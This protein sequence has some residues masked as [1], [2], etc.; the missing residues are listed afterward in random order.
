MSQRK[1][2]LSIK[3]ANDLIQQGFSVIEVKP[4]NRYQG[5]AAFIF[6][7]T[8]ALNEALLEISKQRKIKL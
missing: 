4:S 5:K 3:I 6:K 2:I 8:P 7:V 1:V